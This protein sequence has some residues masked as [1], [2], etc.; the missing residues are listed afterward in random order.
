[1]REVFIQKKG[2]RLANDTL[3]VKIKNAQMRTNTFI[4]PIS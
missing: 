3:Q 4:W 2:Q 1:M